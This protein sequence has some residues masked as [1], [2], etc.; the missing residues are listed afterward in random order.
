[1]KLS[2]KA[3]A[4]FYLTASLGLG[5][6][7]L[8]YGQ[9]PGLLK[10]GVQTKEY[11]KPQA[12]PSLSRND[13]NQMGDPFSSDAP[14]GPGT[15]DAPDEAFNQRPFNLD[16]QQGNQNLQYQ[17]P[18]QQQAMF[19]QQAQQSGG[20]RFPLSAEQEEQHPQ[21]KLAWDQWHKRVAGAIYSRFNGLATTAFKQSKPM[22]CEVA[23]TVTRDRKIQNIQLIQKS[24]NIVFNTMVYGV[25]K[26]MNGDPLLDFPQGSAR[27]TVDKSG[28]FLW[29]YKVQGFKYTINDQ[30][31]I[32]QRR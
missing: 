27:Q 4:L 13:M 2:A 24:P 17:Q 22:A 1:M 8:A 31:T 12:A 28:T 11:V 30:E 16:A 14:G 7:A 26:S 29:N 9:G 23:Y 18:M 19:Q 5:T 25:V 32:K 15:F 6:N 10:G 20:Q 21:M 3:L